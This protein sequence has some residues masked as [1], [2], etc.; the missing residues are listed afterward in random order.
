MYSVIKSIKIVGKDQ[1]GN[2][3]F[4]FTHTSKNAVKLILFPVPIQ[5]CV[6]HLIWWLLNNLL[7]NNILGKFSICTLAAFSTATGWL[8]AVDINS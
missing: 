2:G 3:Y 7:A 1:A 5:Y 6:N 4:I 8:A